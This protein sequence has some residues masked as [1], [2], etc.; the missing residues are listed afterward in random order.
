MRITQKAVAQTSLHG[1]NQ[2]LARL[3]KLQQQLT[4]GTQ[5]SK[6]SDSP[7]GTNRAM[8][9]RKDQA[10]AVQYARNISDGQGWLDSADTALNSMISQV[11]KVR[12]LTVQGLN[13]G[14][15][16]RSSQQAISSEVSALRSS[17]LGVAN[18]TI[19]GRSLFGGVTQGTE[20]Y[21]GNGT[22]KGI[23]GTSGWGTVAGVPV[24]PTMRRV[25]ESEEI[26]T[27][28]TGPEA[29]GDPD[30]GDDLFAVIARIA[31]HVT[32]DPDSLKDDLADLDTAYDRLLSAASSIGARSARMQVASRVNADLQLTLKSQ[33]S[34]VE[35]IDLPKTIM[36]M[37][38]QETGYQAALSATSKVI[39]PTLVDFLR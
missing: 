31:D 15:L 26:R 27:D 10:A 33:L 17:L 32:T 6:P 21:D 9:L 29:F 7:T 24:L 3:G 14:A 35:D 25:S 8:Q 23:G 11:K 4:S 37:N 18:Q 13:G 38:L 16:S 34:G 20:A 5:I 30:L 28:I 2:N 12:D 22:Y 36:E 1:L 39:Q 19:S